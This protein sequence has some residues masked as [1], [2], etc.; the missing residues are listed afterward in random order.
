MIEYVP[1]PRTEH[2]AIFI[3]DLA[4]TNAE[5]QWYDHVAPDGSPW[6]IV[7]YDFVVDHSILDTLRLDY[8]GE[9]IR[10][11]WSPACLNWDDGVP[12]VEAGI[13]LSPPDGIERYGPPAELAA[14][15]ADWFADNIVRWTRSERPR[16]WKTNRS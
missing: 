15:A 3:R 13:D 7:S 2:E 12:A 5:L 1:E 8:D 16:R 6:L 11:G 4:A 9:A 10:G 14:V